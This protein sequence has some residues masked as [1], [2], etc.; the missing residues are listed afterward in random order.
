MTFSI[1][2]T[3]AFCFTL[4]VGGYGGGGRGVGPGGFVPGGVG[5]GGLGIGGLGPGGLGG[6]MKLYTLSQFIINN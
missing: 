4:K 6:G 5:P 1:T 3:L 2:K